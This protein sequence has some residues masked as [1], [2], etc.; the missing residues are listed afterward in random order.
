MLL[1]EAVI[2]GELLN[3]LACVAV[4]GQLFLLDLVHDADLLGHFELPMD[5]KKDFVGAVA[6]AVEVLAAL[7]GALD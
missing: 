4:I 1:I 7:D 3:Q 5:D 2:C 6:L